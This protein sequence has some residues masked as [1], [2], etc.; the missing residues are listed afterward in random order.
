MDAKIYQEYDALKKENIPEND[1]KKIT[2]FVDDLALEGISEIR[3]VH[4]VP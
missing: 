3:K 2:G 4:G 1:K